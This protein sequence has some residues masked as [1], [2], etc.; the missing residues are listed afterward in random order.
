ML[1]VADMVPEANVQDNVTEVVAVEVEP[2]CIDYAM[3]FINHDQDSRC[4]TA[5]AAGWPFMRVAGVHMRMLG[6]SGGHFSDIWDILLAAQP[7]WAFFDVVVTFQIDKTSS[8]VL[9]Q[10]VEIREIEILRA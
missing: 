1:P 4:I 5:A 9:I 2:E 7:I 8:D 3:A 6:S 10:A